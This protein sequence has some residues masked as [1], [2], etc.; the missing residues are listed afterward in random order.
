MQDGDHN[1]FTVKVFKFTLSFCEI[2]HNRQSGL[3]SVIY[4]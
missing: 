1:T 2:I 3:T 4:K